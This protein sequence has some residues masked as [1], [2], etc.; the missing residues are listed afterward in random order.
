MTR[1]LHTHRLAAW[2]TAAVLG[3]LFGMPSLVAANPLPDA[4]M[5]THVQAADPDFCTTNSITTCDEIVQITTESGP[6]EFGLFFQPIAGMPEPIEGFT[7]EAEWPEDWT[8]QGI[9]VCCGEYAAAIVDN[10]IQ[11]V[12][13]ADPGHQ[14]DQF[15]LVAHITLDVESAGR[16]AITGADVM[17]EGGVAL[18]IDGVPALA[19]V[20]CGDCTQPC[21][22]GD[23]C[24]ARADVQ[25][26]EMSAAQGSQA[27]AVFR[28]WASG[29]NPLCDVAFDSPSPFLLVE[30]EV[31]AMGGYD[32]TVTADATGLAPGNHFGYVRAYTNMPCETCIPVYLTVTPGTPAQR[33]TWGGI[34]S[35]FR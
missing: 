23:A 21:D 11:I 17:L 13:T 1:S 4:A 9:R 20:P 28:G 15:F 3:A 18:W 25:I 8:Y 32:V 19:G 7:I 10:T 22:Y 26:L 31:S 5:F 35:V 33:A 2:T 24:L 6:R 16:F 12:I 14:M 30:F 27:Q 29:M 34:K